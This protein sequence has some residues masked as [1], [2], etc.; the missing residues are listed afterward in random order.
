[1][2]RFLEIT[3]SLLA[4]VGLV[5]GG[6]VLWGNAQF[7]RPGPSTTEITLVIERDAGVNIIARDLYQAGVL[8]HQFPFRI[9][10][11][12]EAK[13][14]PLRAGEY[15]FKAGISPEAVLKHLQSGK[16]VVRRVTFA[17]G[18]TTAEIL[19]QLG[20]TKGLKG[21]VS[22][23][24][25][26]GALLP[27]TYHFSFGDQR[28]TI[29][30]RMRRDMQG[31]LARLWANRAP[32][33]PLKSAKE[34]LVLASIIEK[35]TGVAAERPRI[36]GVFINRLNKK[37]R[38]QSDPTVAY[39][40]TEGNG[41]LGR[42]LTRADLKRPSAYNTYLIDGLPPEPICNPGSASL[43]A[44]LRPAPT[45]E[46]YFVADGSGGHV[47]AKTLKEH[48]RNVARWRKINRTRN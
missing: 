33:L 28:L 25:A 44:V 2:G 41:Q 32:D 9:M 27:E 45:K 7:K 19:A 48:N 40:L 1:M 46:L 43:E 42:P 31:L 13:E 16:T 22:P 4:G 29:I 15:A 38:L 39:G 8:S 12:L 24:P 21:L 11:R 3:L 10:A 23:I 36:A 37:M 26:E 34:A 5:L 17:E 14:K 47:F 35:E 6:A 18:L 20:Q 30:K